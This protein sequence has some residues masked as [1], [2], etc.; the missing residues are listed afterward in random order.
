MFSDICTEQIRE[1]F[2]FASYGNF[3][4][5]MNKNNGF[6]NVTKLCGLV[7]K[8]FSDWKININSLRLMHELEDE[9][10]RALEFIPYTTEETLQNTISVN[11]ETV[12]KSIV[13]ANQTSEDKLISGT[14]CHPL[15]IP[16]IAS[17]CSPAFAIKV[18]KVINHCIVEE[19][20]LRL[21]K[22]QDDYRRL[23]QQQNTSLQIKQEEIKE[24]KEHHQTWSNTHAFAL[25]RL[26]DPN[27]LPYYAIRC[28]HRDMSTAI[29]KLRRR[30]PNCE[31]LYLQ[32]KVPN[33][34]N[35]FDR[36]KKN[37]SIKTKRNYCAIV[38]NDY[39]KLIDYISTIC[40]VN[41]A[42]S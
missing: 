41:N 37:N 17:W 10:H 42:S 35:L 28:K 9:I 13:T 14:Y 26:N 20:K 33:A 31:V 18:S 25:L 36:L 2:W 1:N 4:V 38:D 16:H 24:M 15:L 19:W 29:N 23:L 21:E 32:K 22:V 12:C 7:N 3:K 39:Q 8:K 34:I 5:I 27:C 30:H 40:A 11:L 6:I